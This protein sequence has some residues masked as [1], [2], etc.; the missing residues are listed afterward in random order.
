MV[1]FKTAFV[2][3]IQ[4]VAASALDI[5]VESTGNF[6]GGYHY[7]FLHEDIN[8]S[9]DGGIYA[10]LVRNRAFQYS[11]RYP[12]SLDGWRSINS[13]NLSLSRLAEPLS[14]VLPVSVN[15][16]ATKNSG[17]R[18]VGLQNEGYWGMDVKRHKYTG[19]FWV[20]GAYKGYFTAELRSNL[21][22][23]V[24]GSVKVKS[25]AVA[26]DWVEH[27]FEL[28]PKKDAPNSNNTFAITFDPKGASSGSLDF[29]LISLFPP[30]Y[31]N[32]KNGLRKDIAEALEELHP[33]ILRFPG[34]N[35]LEGLTHSTY[36]NWKDS[37]GPLRTRPGFQG[38]WN[39]QQTHGLGLMEYLYWAEDMGLDIVIG[40]WAG[41]SLDGEVTPKADFQAV[42]DEGLEQIEFIRGA[43]DSKWGSVRA[44]LGHPEPFKLNYVEIGNEDWLAG[45]PGGWSSYKSY[46]LPLFVEAINNAYDDIT[47]IASGASTDGDGFNIPTKVVGDYHPYRSPDALVDEFDRFD[48]DV[49]HIVGEVAAV[50]P[51]GGI[52]WSGNL[53]PFPW[54]I[55]TVGEAIS[56]IGY[57]RNADHVPGTFYAPVLRNMNE[58]QWAV[59]ILQF[60]ADTALTTRSTS[61]YIWELF[62]KYPITRVLTATAEFDPAFYVVGSNEDLGT[63]VWKGAVYNTTNSADVPITVAFEGVKAGTK[64]ELTVLTNNSEDPYAYNDPLTGVNIVDRTTTVLEA[65]EKGVFE[66]VLPEL[67]VAVLAATVESAT[68]TRRSRGRALGA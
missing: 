53:M 47:V 49:S 48:N 10:E 18:R 28:L 65:N 2:A 16:K 67:S 35:M 11:D 25:H 12:V 32:R 41:L 37:L 43:A 60:A 55:G 24:F 17:K 19:S 14:D 7:G 54:W 22:E 63:L 1:S 36:W 58:W 23:D 52:G 56:L 9:G 8:N 38:V 40:I 4:I 20:R 21:T 27:E 50:H 62:A 15:V 5:S 29:N 44:E 13:A 68:K 61:W 30:T 34:G 33:T 3:A 31:K 39:Y 6:T 66:F 42:I 45:Y 26:N 59:T 64:A 51:N 46:R 57:E